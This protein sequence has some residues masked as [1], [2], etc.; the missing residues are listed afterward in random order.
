MPDQLHRVL[1]REEWIKPAGVLG[2]F[3]CLFNDGV[4]AQGFISS[5][6]CMQ[7]PF[8]HDEYFIYLV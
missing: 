5:K 7:E 1:S 4:E 8:T 3:Y 2:F 6:D